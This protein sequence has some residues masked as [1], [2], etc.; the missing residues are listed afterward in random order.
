MT[1]LE[2][3][4]RSLDT[5]LFSA[6]PSQMSENDKKALLL[7]QNCVKNRGEYIYLE[8]GSHLGGT[9][10]PFYADSACKLIY[11]IDKR[12]EFQPDERRRMSHY[13]DNSTERML[14]N[15]SN[16]FPSILD[17]K[18]R[19]FDC[20]AS[21]L[22]PSKIIEKPDL[23]FID[24]EHTNEAVFSDFKFCIKICHPN[25]IIA[26][27]DAWVIFKGIEKIKKFLSK[28]SI[29]FRGFILLG[30]VYAILFNESISAYTE[31]LKPL[32]VDEI[33]YFKRSRNYLRK[34]YIKSK[35]PLFYQFLRIGKRA[36][37]T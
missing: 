11:S 8:I 23:C 33:K 36:L 14:S 16:A 26:F 24:A 20:D 22:D 1:S 25:A 15:L 37:K 10:Q 29:P 35:Y 12:P 6:I 3:R 21:D 32:S 17:K 9:I 28:N 31:K 34:I 2:E 19:T 7:L 4:I 30:N 18:I 27:H 13:P 5:S